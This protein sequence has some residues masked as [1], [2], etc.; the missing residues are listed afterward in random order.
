MNKQ[1]LTEEEYWD[2]RWERLKLPVEIT[3]DN[4]RAVT[5]EMMNVFEM[6]LPKQ[7]GLRI[8]EIGGAPGKWLAYF[9]KHFH[10]D[11]NAIDYSGT[12]C[13]KM[14][15]NFALLHLEAKIYRSNIL[16]DDLSGLTPFDIVYS[17]GFIEHFQDL[18]V[19]LEKH[20]EMVRGG[21][22]LILG[23]PNFLGITEH[24]LRRTAPRMLTTH[25]LQAMDL[26][27]WDAFEDKYHLA[28]I[29]KGYIGG[30][31]LH[32]CRRC[33]K[34]T[35]LNRLIRLFFKA[36]TRLT[37]EIPFLR[38]YNSKCWSPYFLVL[39]KKG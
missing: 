4:A 10:Y 27:T 3:K 5:R 29:F 34:R 15:E 36:L 16:T 9:K 24:F 19:I 7:N 31:D 25:N 30:F 11:I 38:K 32:N 1:E 18:S 28:P 13:Q 6:Y 17:L 14:R 23:V 33:E 26:K 37:R 35:P 20:L 22:I 21:G 2:G 39:Y 8:L 12:G